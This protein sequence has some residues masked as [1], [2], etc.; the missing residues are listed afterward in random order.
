MHDWSVSYVPFWASTWRSLGIVFVYQRSYMSVHTYVVGCGL[1]I[2]DYCSFT[3]CGCCSGDALGKKMSHVHLVRRVTSAQAHV[4]WTSRVVSNCFFS[5]KARLTNAGNTSWASKKRTNNLNVVSREQ[6]WAPATKTWWP[7]TG[8]DALLLPK[9]E[10][11][12]NRT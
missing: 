8:W 12:F 3:F 10:N 1:D 7:I 4:M 2:T 6:R 5:L 9:T 11:P